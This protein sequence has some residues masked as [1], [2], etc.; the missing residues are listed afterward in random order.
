MSFIIAFTEKLQA[1]RTD[2]ADNTKIN[3]PLNYSKK[4]GT[5]DFLANPVL[6]PRTIEAIQ[7]ENSG[8]SEYRP[9]EIQY[10]PHWGTEDLVTLDSG[11]VCAKNNQRRD[12]IVTEEPDLF[13]YH[14]FT[15]EEN[16]IRE[17]KGDTQKRLNDGFRSSMRIGRESMDSQCMAK[18]AANIGTNPAQNAAANTYTDVQMLLSGGADVATFDSIINDQEDNF[19]GG[20]IGIIGQGGASNSNK[21]FNRLSVGNLNTTAGIDMQAVAAQFGMLYFKDQSTT[22]N[23]GTANRVLAIYPGLSQIYSYNLYLGDFA[24][25]SPDN[26]IKGTMRDPIYPFLW[27][28]KITYNDNCSTGNGLQGAWVVE[29][30]KYFDIFLTPESAFGDVYGELDGFNGVLGYNITSS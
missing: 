24:R 28:Y 23:L 7:R 4:T 9:V 29:V 8:R 21:Y 3:D 10:Q 22:A 25:V 6:N 11:V 26:A 5:I 18:L 19:M 1:V 2:L 12:T 20:P 16:F 13:A 27:D 14:K 17:T 15:L 30:F